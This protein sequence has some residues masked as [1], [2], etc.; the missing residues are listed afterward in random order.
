[1]TNCKYASGMAANDR[2]G[3]FAASL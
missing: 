3:L 2:G 1:M